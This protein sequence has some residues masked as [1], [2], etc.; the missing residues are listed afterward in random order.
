MIF[1]NVK[2]SDRLR[3]KAMH[4][5]CEALNHT[6]CTANIDNK[7]PHEMWHGPRT[8]T[9]A[10]PLPFSSRHPAD[11]SDRQSCCRRRK[12]LLPRTTD[13]PSAR[14]QACADPGG[15]R[16]KDE[17]NHV[18]SHAIKEPNATAG[19]LEGAY[20]GERD[21]KRRRLFAPIQ[22]PP[23]GRG[24][25]HVLRTSNAAAGGGETGQL[26]QLG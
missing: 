1:L 15:A 26:E 23:L 18:G 8:P 7:S 6:A 2:L 25:S 3:A 24:I 16:G 14:L 4:W 13:L 12:V 5:A 11:G 19:S 20:G 17:R 9:P 22:P 10:A 21:N